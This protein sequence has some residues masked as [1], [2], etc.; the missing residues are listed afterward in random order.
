MGAQR[1]SWHAWWHRGEGGE[2]GALLGGYSVLLKCDKV[3]VS[4]M[5]CVVCMGVYLQCSLQGSS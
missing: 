4:G 1:S 3:C 2:G 5:S